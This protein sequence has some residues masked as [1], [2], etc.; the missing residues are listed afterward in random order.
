MPGNVTAVT[1]LLPRAGQALCLLAHDDVY[2]SPNPRQVEVIRPSVC[3]PKSCHHFPRART[4]AYEPG[5]PCTRDSAR[6]MARQTTELIV[7]EPCP[8]GGFS[9]LLI[10][11]GL[12]SLRWASR[13]LE[14]TSLTVAL[15]GLSPLSS[16]TWPPPWAHSTSCPVTWPFAAPSSCGVRGR[17]PGWRWSACPGWVGSSVGGWAGGW[18]PALES[19]VFPWA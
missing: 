8:R 3:A 9:S 13:S 4:L 16:G 14:R 18:G 19:G 7:N 15:G 6:H 12:R 1:T 2:L 5:V 10:L 11:L 17:G